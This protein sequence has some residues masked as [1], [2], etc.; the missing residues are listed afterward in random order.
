MAFSQGAAPSAEQFGNRPA[1]LQY[2]IYTKVGDITCRH[3]VPMAFCACE[4]AQLMHALSRSSH[5]AGMTF[6]A[7]ELNSK[8]NETNKLWTEQLESSLSARL[9]TTSSKSTSDELNDD[10]TNTSSE[11]CGR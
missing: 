2:I 3:C 1:P 11:T 7:S 8:L 4:H 6:Y 9:S 5:V 10:G